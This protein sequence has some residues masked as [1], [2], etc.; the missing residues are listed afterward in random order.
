LP[1]S[2]IKVVG[3]AQTGYTYF[4]ARD[5]VPGESDL[6]LAIISPTLFQHYSEQVYSMTQRYSDLSTFPRKDGV[7]V[8]RSFRLYL[9]SGYFRPDFMPNSPLRADWFGFFNKLSTQHTDVF[10]NITSGI[11]LSEGFFE[12][13]NASIVEVYRKAQ[14]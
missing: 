13:K 8:A 6:D 4:S 5:F 14:S 7:D 2:S 1:F 10:R 12:M 9:G 11:Y 3:S